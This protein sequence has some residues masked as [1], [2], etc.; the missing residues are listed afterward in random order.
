M[1]LKI[2]L[3]KWELVESAPRFSDIKM[4]IDR[5][6]CGEPTVLIP[7]D[8]G[9]RVNPGWFVRRISDGKRLDGVRV[10]K[11]GLR[12]RFEVKNGETQ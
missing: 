11:S 6:Y 8:E 2:C 9:A 7:I 4:S 1:K 3:T 5:F 10:I 12:Y